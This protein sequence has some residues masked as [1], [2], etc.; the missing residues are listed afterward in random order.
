MSM[1]SPQ[2]AVW[3]RLRPER[4]EHDATLEMRPCS[5]VVGCWPP[6][7]QLGTSRLRHAGRPGTWGANGVPDYVTMYIY[8]PDNRAENPPVV[9][10]CHSCGTPVSGYVNSISGIMS[11]ADR[12]G[13]IIILPEATGRNCWDV[14]SDPSLMHDGGG[15]TQ[16][17]AQMV[18]YTLSQY[19]GDPERVYIMGG[20]WGAMMTQAMLAVYPDLFQAGSARAGVAAGCCPEGG[21]RLGERDAC[22]VP[23]RH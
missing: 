16:A 14:G 6:R 20:S 7:D 22:V 4:E 11:A 13:F 19:N 15:D 23:V 18:E 12:N 8:V 1:G 21:H 17:V 2:A 5:R 3:Y 10:A 9:V